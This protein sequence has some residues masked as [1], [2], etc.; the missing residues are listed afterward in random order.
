MNL[1]SELEQLEIDGVLMHL[2]YA[3]RDFA[4][5][6]PAPKMHELEE[7]A[8]FRFENQGIKEAIVLKA[9]RLQSLVRASLVL[10]QHGFIQ[11]LGILQRAISETQ[12]DILFLVFGVT[13]R[14]GKLHEKYL[15]EFWRKPVDESGQ[16]KGHG[17][18]VPR[19]K[20]RAYVI[21]ETNKDKKYVESEGIRNS[22]SLYSFESGYV[23]GASEQI[24]DLY[25]PAQNILRVPS[26]HTKGLAGTARAEEYRQ[27]FWDYIYRSVRSYVQI[28]SALGLHHQ[29][30][31]LKGA[32]KLILKNGRV[33]FKEP[34]K[35]KAKEQNKHRLV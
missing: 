4:E 5:C 6:V 15:D 8:I 7:G 29:A 19:K 17:N 33:T 32:A 23:H 21:K 25:Y 26:F 35:N 28:A 34:P 20:I 16:L 3:F 22:R 31:Q 11:E 18:S 30:K 13:L 12:E 14:Q 10:A 9:A 2:D 24:M 1:G 27:D